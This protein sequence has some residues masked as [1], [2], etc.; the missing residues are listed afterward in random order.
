MTV[1]LIW[2]DINSQ[3]MIT[4]S[5][6][7]SDATVEMLGQTIWGSRSTKYRIMNISEK[8][9]R[10]RNPSYFVLS[11]AGQELCVF[12]L[13][14]CSKFLAGRQCNGFHF[15]MAST[16]PDRQNQGLAGQLIEHVGEY[17]KSEVGSPGFGFAYV[18]ETTEYSLHLSDQ[19]GHTVEAD[20]P[21]TLFA[22]FF[23]RRDPSAG[24]IRPD[25]VQ[26]I[27]ARLEESYKDHELTDFP[28]S[29]K[30][31]EC[32]VSREGSEIVAVAQAELLR[33]A[34]VSMPGI[35]GVFLLNILKRLPWFNRLL[36][37]EDLRIVRIGNLIL[38]KGHE[39]AFFSLLETCLHY[40]QAKIGLIMLDARSPSFRAIREYGKMG[41]LA[42]S[43]SGSAKLRIDVVGM[44]EMMLA[45][46]RNGPLMVSAGDV[47]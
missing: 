29:F 1:E 47:L 46:L 39:A 2:K 12:V 31:E 23:P 10:L 42:H 18:E 26:P 35:Q 14:K 36:N 21:L 45:Q 22:R 11:E 5:D 28:S 19:I 32:F 7:P 43:I 44:N 3:K 15:V 17:C 25:E 41:L 38:N 27:M 20:I 13:D 37:L 4:R 34:V 24:L 33:W 9:A 40:H 8:L 6:K 16:R 30:S